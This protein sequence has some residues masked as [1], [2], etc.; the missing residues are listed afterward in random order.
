ML[1]VHVLACVFVVCSLLFVCP[2]NSLMMV[3]FVAVCLLRC[4]VVGVFVVGITVL[5]VCVTCLRAC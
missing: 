1:L 5:I 4:V 2:L 3:L